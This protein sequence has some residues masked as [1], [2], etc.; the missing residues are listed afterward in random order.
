M[1]TAKRQSPKGTKAPSDVD[2][3]DDI[4]RIAII[5]LFSD[6]QLMDR[7]VLKGGTA[8]DLIHRVSARASVDIDISID[9]EV[10]LSADQL[11]NRLQDNFRAAFLTHDIHVF[12]VTLE[13]VPPNITAE[14]MGFWGGYRV[15][16]KLISTE[17]ARFLK[18]DL[19]QMRRQSIQLGQQG[20][21]R[22][23][24]SKHEFCAS[25]APEEI[26]GYRIY[27]YT[28]E[29]MVAEKLRAL[30]QQTPTY[31]SQ[32]KKHCA[33]RARDFLDIYLLIEHFKLDM[34][35]EENISLIQ[36]VFAAKKVSPDQFKEVREQREFHRIDFFS[37]EEVI[38]P[39]VTI[40]S[41]DSYFD[42]VS[43]LTLR[44]EALWNI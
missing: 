32:L 27:A 13:E 38:K 40:M 2:R 11:L 24:I 33:P 1:A 44:I 26:S 34:T 7:F 23:D 36:S 35:R 29:M 30:C 10:E 8:L 19:E 39:G 9:G 20:R 3:L 28:P 4:K 14:F 18:Y 12:D 21:F 15:H 31:A 25:K 17:Q 43:E 41:F 5:A 16:F 37:V 22:V 42:Y 6:D